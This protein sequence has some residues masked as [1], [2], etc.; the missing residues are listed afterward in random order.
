[1]ESLPVKCWRKSK[2]NSA[3][4][5][6]F[7]RERFAWLGAWLVHI[8]I[9][10]RTAEFERALERS[11]W[12]FRGMRFLDLF[13]LHCGCKNIPYKSRRHYHARLFFFSV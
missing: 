3:A 2:N 12:T 11:L 8:D 6:R 9:R 5:I 10:C 1:M 13:A 7:W 4:K